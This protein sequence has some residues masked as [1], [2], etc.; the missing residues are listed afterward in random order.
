MRVADIECSAADFNPVSPFYGTLY[1]RIQFHG[2]LMRRT[3]NKMISFDHYC[4]SIQDFLYSRICSICN[5]YIPEPL[6]LRNHYKVHQ[7]RYA[8]G[9]TGVNDSVK[10]EEETME[11]ANELIDPSDLPKPPVNFSE[12]SVFLFTDLTDWLR[13]DFEEDRIVE[14][15]PKSIAAQANAMIRKDKQNTS[16]SVSITEAEPVMISEASNSTTANLTNGLEDNIQS[17]ATFS[18]DSALDTDHMKTVKSEVKVEHDSMIDQIEQ[19]NVND[20]ENSSFSIRTDSYDDLSDLLD[21][22]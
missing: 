18:V 21:K 19:L 14:Q 6:R 13:S 8:L 12:G 15:K 1:Q 7:Q 10:K 2:I 20:D 4:P 16:N 9:R 3:Q 22:I 5:Q 17:V 11:D